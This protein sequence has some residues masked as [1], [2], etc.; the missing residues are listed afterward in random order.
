M[1][2]NINITEEDIFQFVNYTE[3]LSIEKREFI[4]TNYDK[5]KSQI[6]FYKSFHKPLTK[7]EKNELDE[8][9]T[10]MLSGMNNY[11]KLIPTYTEDPHKENKFRLAAASLTL[12]KKTDSISYAD[13]ESKF[14]IRII[15]NEEKTVLHLLPNTNDYSNNH[16]EITLHPSENKYL[17]TDVSVPVEINSESEIEIID[18]IELKN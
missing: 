16:Y 15:I 9:V 10:R 1:K 13:S 5:Y 7:T 11:Y 14:L 12:K 8:K 3:I 2:Y 4:E 18:L 6:D 17:I